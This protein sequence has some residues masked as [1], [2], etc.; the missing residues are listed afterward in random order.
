MVFLTCEVLETFL[1]ILKEAWLE[2]EIVGQEAIQERGK[3]VFLVFQLQREKGFMNIAI[4]DL[5]FDN[6]HILRIYHQNCT[7]IHIQQHMDYINTKKA[8]S[9]SKI[10]K[11]TALNINYFRL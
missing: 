2:S 8:H 9:L 4:Q 11:Q 3:T 7:E 6:D 10:I 1:W 5:G